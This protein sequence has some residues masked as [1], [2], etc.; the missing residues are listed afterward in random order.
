MFQTEGDTKQFMQK[1]KMPGKKRHCSHKVDVAMERQ[2]NVN[3]LLAGSLKVHCK[4]TLAVQIALHDM[5]WLLL[6]AHICVIN[7]IRGRHMI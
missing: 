3:S 1:L 6:I 5:L 7:S 2:L 4:D